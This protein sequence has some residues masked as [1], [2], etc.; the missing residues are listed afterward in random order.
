MTAAVTDA[1][2]TAGMT[3]DGLEKLKQAENEMAAIVAKYNIDVQT[4][5]NA[6]RD[7][8]RNREIKTGDEWTPRIIATVVL[9]GFFV[10]LGYMIKYG[11]AQ[12]ASGATFT[13]IGGL[14]FA[15]GSI[16]GYYFGSTKGSADKTALIAKAASG[17]KHL[18]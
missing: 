11:I 1:I 14:N 8:A 15:F 10:S 3:S 13:L 6:D 12:D 2:Q 18:P 9:V 17:D 7:S 5:D 16:I 4:L